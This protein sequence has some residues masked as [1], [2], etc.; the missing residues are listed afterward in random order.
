MMKARMGSSWVHPITHSQLTD[1]SQPLKIGMLNNIIYELARNSKKSVKRVVDYLILVLRH[2][3]AKLRFLI[4]NEDSF[5]IWSTLPH[6]IQEYLNLI[7]HG[8]IGSNW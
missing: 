1:S 5:R 2:V 7:L 3:K 4:P 8:V 6:L